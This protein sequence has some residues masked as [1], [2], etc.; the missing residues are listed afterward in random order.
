M[1]GDSVKS[2]VGNKQVEV[3]VG[4]AFTQALLSTLQ[5]TGAD[6]LTYVSL[7]KRMDKIAL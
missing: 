5:S 4:S 6:K 3:P 7:L 1:D 2:F